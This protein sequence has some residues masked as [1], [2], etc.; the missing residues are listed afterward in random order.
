MKMNFTILSFLCLGVLMAC[1]EDSSKIPDSPTMLKKVD[2]QFGLESQET[3]YMQENPGNQ[4]PSW[5]AATTLELTSRTDGEF[6]MHGASVNNDTEITIFYLNGKKVEL[7]VLMRMGDVIKGY[8]V[9][10]NR[11]IVKFEVYTNNGTVE[12]SML[13]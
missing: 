2:V 9:D 7:P 1:S 5:S 10:F 4:L 13:P 6:Y 11:S 12:G 8:L 3:T